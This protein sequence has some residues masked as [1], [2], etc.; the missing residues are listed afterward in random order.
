MRLSLIKHG[1]WIGV[2]VLATGACD[3]D[4]LNTDPN[5]PVE[6][7]P[8]VLLPHAEMTF[9]FSELGADPQWYSSVLVQ[10]TAGVHGQL[11]DADHLA[12]IDN[13]T[14]NNSWL[15][16]Y[17][18]VLPDLQVIID[19]ASASGNWDFVGV[20]K[21]LMAMTYAH[22]TDLWGQIPF[23][24]AGEGAEGL[25]PTYDEQQFIYDSLQVMLD[26]AIADLAKDSPGNAMAVDLVYGPDVDDDFELWTELWTK[27]AWGVKARLYNRLSKRDPEGSATNALAALANSFESSEEDMT[28][29]GYTSAATQEHPWYQERFDRSH[30]AWSER[31]DDIMVAHDDPRREIFAQ[32]MPEDTDNAGEIVPAPNGSAL[33]DQAGGIYSKLSLNIIRPDAPQP[34]ITYAELKF[35]EAEAHWRLD[36]DVQALAAF[37]EAVAAALEYADV[38]DAD[39]AAYMAQLDVIPLLPNQLTLQRIIEEKWIFFFPFQATEAYND[40]RRTGFPMLT[41]PAG[42]IPRRFPIAQRERDTNNT[43]VPPNS[44]N[45]VQNGSGVWWDDGTED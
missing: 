38:D 31:M 12:R 40:W 5:N 42:E 41:N 1:I 27:A 17:S 9:I 26:E 36:Q 43:N 15:N 35:I 19:E 10:H 29:T 6:A 18:T 3:F 21:V 8:A 34:M 33:L 39:A 22:A 24:E 11:N 30:H 16:I 13:T 28:F 20:S 4:A 25:Q 37:E 23:S 7:S 14:L 32:P 2:L 45:P 44:V